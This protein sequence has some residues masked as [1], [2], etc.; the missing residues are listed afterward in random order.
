MDSHA[1][2]LRVQGADEE[3][4]QALAKGDLAGAPVTEAE[5]ALL[6]FAELVT[7]AA[8][9]TR[10]GDT[11]RLRG[12]GWSD[13]QIAEAVYIIAMFAF[14]NRV[15]DAFGIEPMGYLESNTLSP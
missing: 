9:Q 8:H 7:R 10:P 14:F 1:Y 3:I 5:R 13:E 4:V 11:N 6:R 12:L 2:F 15:A